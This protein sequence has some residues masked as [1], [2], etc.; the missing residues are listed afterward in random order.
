MKRI[1]LAAMLVVFVRDI[2]TVL[3]LESQGF[4]CYEVARHGGKGGF[5]HGW[6]CEITSRKD[7]PKGGRR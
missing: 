4:D 5:T 1:V 6:N 7:L 3:Y 2:G